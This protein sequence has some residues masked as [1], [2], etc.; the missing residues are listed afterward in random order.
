MN[1]D[2]KRPCKSCPFRT[3]IEPFLHPGR[4]EEIT[5][6]ILHRDCS[7]ACHNTLEHDEDGETKIHSGSQHCAGAMIFLELQDRPN[8]MMRIAERL[9]LYDARKLIMDSPVYDNA[10]DMIDAQKRKKK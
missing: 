10:T 8:Q 2:L 9:G 1:F 3:D 7:F 4:V 6:Q 5:D